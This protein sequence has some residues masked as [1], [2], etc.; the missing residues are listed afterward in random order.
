M[1]LPRA[2]QPTQS[3]Y[4]SNAIT[5]T[6]VYPLPISMS[7]FLRRIFLYSLAALATAES[8][9]ADFPFQQIIRVTE[10]VIALAAPGREDTL[11]MMALDQ[12]CTVTRP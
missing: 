4:P 12:C 8:H 6:F 1:R 9:R 5:V 3:A 7:P 2:I 11:T 10:S